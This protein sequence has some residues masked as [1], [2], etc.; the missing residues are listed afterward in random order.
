MQ[1]ARR[2]SGELVF[3]PWR[4]LELTLVGSGTREKQVTKGFVQA[5]AWLWEGNFRGAGDCQ[6]KCS[7]SAGDHLTLEGKFQGFRRWSSDGE[8]QGKAIA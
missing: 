8:D 1:G 5:I 3:Q 6:A 4:L 7:L 2:V